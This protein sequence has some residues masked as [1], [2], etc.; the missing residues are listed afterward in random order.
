MGN[1]IIFFITL[2]FSPRFISDVTLFATQQH[3]VAV[4]FRL[5]RIIFFQLRFAIDVYIFRRLRYFV[6]FL[7]SRLLLFFFHMM[8]Y[9]APPLAVRA[10][11]R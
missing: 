4:H 1:V 5:R 10:R 8:P 9:Q 3:H 11:R 2:R 7:S 6:T